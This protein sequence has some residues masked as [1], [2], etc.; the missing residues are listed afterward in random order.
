M[1]LQ[2]IKKRQRILIQRPHIHHTYISHTSDRA[3]SLDVAD[4]E[5]GEVSTKKIIHI[6]LNILYLVSA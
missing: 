3:Q 2:K 5:V 6:M 4:S 1:E